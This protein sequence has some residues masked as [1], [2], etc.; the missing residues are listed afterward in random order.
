MVGRMRQLEAKILWR[1]PEEQ[2]P[3]CPELEEDEEPWQYLI[4]VEGENGAR[5]TD[6]AI[7]EFWQEDSYDENPQWYW[8]WVTRT[9]SYNYDE[10]LAW[11]E[12]P[13]F[14]GFQG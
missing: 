1:D 6:S 8:S 13:Q 11:A 9:W 12:Y 10:I 4:A 7:P 3:F 2:P 14:D 5:F